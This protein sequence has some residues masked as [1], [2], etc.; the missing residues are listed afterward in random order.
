MGE[1]DKIKL[2]LTKR[3]SHAKA[4]KTFVGMIGDR[5]GLAAMQGL[6]EAGDADG[7]GQLD[8]GEFQA[9]IDKFQAKSETKITADEVQGLFQLI[10][11]N[12]DGK[13]SFEVNSLSVPFVVVRLSA[14]PPLPACEVVVVSVH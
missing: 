5:S 14:S 3:D 12:G 7:N 2:Y 13:L 8:L 1:E 10:D 11:M 4:I 9:M 6:F